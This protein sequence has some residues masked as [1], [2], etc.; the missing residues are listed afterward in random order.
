MYIRW[1]TVVTVNV[2]SIGGLH[3]CSRASP[4]SNPPLDPNRE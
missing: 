1:V 3:L 2:P 4:R